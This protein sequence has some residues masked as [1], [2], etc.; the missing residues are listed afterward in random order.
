M[1][2]KD[3]VLVDKSCLSS[4]WFQRKMCRGKIGRTKRISDE[5]NKR[6]KTIPST[7]WNLF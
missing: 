5:L 3:Y 1:E 6:N 7:R 4:V 2:S